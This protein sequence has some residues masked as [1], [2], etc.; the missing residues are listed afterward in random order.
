MSIIRIIL[1]LFLS[2]MVISDL[3]FAEQTLKEKLSKGTF[4]VSSEVK[5]CDV[6]SKIFCPGLKHGSKK[7]IMCL[8]A[9]EDKISQNCRDGLGEAAKSV[10]RGLKAIDDIVKS[11]EQDADKFC[12]EVN[13]GK[14]QIVKCLKKHEAN[15]TQNCI[16]TLK[17]TGVWDM[18][19][20]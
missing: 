16:N 18:G 12:L 11:C 13:P 14:G 7:M 2:I 9:Y 5:G 4:N 3:S 8:M 17:K 6:D 19:S 15:V 20:K 10:K 1:V